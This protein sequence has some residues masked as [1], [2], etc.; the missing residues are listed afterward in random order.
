MDVQQVPNYASEKHFVFKQNRVFVPIYDVPLQP[1]WPACAPL[2]ISVI[3]CV[4]AY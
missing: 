2:D 4:Y 1:S 3:I